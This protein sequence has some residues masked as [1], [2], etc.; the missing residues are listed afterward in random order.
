MKIGILG[1]GVSGL[2]MAMRLADAGHDV[3]LFGPPGALGGNMDTARFEI[4][5]VERFADLGVNDFNASTYK[6]LVYWLD[7]LGVEYAR[8]EDTT[9]FFSFDGR[10][11]Y[12]IDGA[13]GTRMPRDVA[14]DFSRFQAEAP[15]DAKSGTYL[16]LTIGQYVAAKGYG[17]A[18]V[19][20]NL[21]PRI[22]A[23]YYCHDVGAATMPFQ[24]VMIY[25]GL[26]EG[27]GGT[28]PRRMYFRDGTSSWTRALFDAGR[29]AGVR[30]HRGPLPSVSANGESV[31]LR[32]PDGE[33]VYDAVVCALHANE[34]VATVRE[35]L[36]AAD[37]EIL[38]GVRYFNSRGYVHQDASLLP[39]NVNAWR[40]FNVAVRAQGSGLTPF[41]MTY[42]ENR[43]QNDA[44]NP[45]FDHFGTPIFFTTLNPIQ[46]V[47]PA[48]VLRSLDGAPVT[49]TFPHNTF[50]LQSFARQR[51]VHDRLQGRAGLFFVG[52]WTK[53]AGLQ[54]ECLL[55]ADFV[56]E[57]LQDAAYTDPHLWHHAR[58]AA[59]VP[60]YFGEAIRS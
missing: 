33:A 42:V 46:P 36:A 25:Y 51:Y 8:L 37:L 29:A 21:L 58:D 48:F 9:S 3:D 59:G 44:C 60:A 6:R 52:G 43:H 1:T 55:S 38:A 11:A 18:F 22:N 57:K 50:D 45:E 53:G 27:F 31:R 26:Q 35:G 49:A 20:T 32:L 13:C 41:S 5:G 19:H 14:A 10:I 15:A 23:M 56:V 17:D 30:L 39:Q 2:Y 34:V 24:A 47:R 54:E 16:D 28:A 12:T 4:G 40:S 7:R